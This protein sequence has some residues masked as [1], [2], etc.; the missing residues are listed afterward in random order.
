MPY[1]VCLCLLTLCSG[2]MPTHASCLSMPALIRIPSCFTEMYALVMLIL[3]AVCGLT[4]QSWRWCLIQAQCRSHSHRHA[5][6]VARRA[7]PNYAPA[8]SAMLCGTAALRVSERTGMLTRHHAS[9]PRTCARPIRRISQSTS[10]SHGH[11]HLCCRSINACD[12]VL[13]H[14][15]E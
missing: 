8:Q 5:A 15:Q 2:E 14:V 7:A 4:D 11:D 10:N 13:L 9:V 12:A 6:P 3:H 1:L